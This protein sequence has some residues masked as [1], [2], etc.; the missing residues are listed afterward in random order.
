MLI[1]LASLAGAAALI[2][3]ASRY[4]DDGLPVHGELILKT[5]VAQPVTGPEAR[6]VDVS[7]RSRP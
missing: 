5:P 3:I 7:S 1:L 2:R 4:P 6:V